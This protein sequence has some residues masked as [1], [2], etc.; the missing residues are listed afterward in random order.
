MSSPRLHHLA[1]LA[2][3]A[4]A[5][6]VASTAPQLKVL[7]VEHQ[8]RSSAAVVVL[9]EVVNHATRPMRLERMQYSFGADG[10]ADAP[11]G[12]VSLDRTIEAGAAV[13]VQLPLDLGNTAIKPGSKLVLDGEL[14]AHENAIERSFPVRAQMT[15]PAEGD[16][17]AGGD[18]DGDA[19]PA[20]EAPSAEQTPAPAP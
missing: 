2:L 8:H 13:V 20:P 5:G 19:A 3:V 7:G 9:V 11:H 16:A 14:F 1:A 4:A 17:D 15:A 6:C 12:E 18:A 10:A